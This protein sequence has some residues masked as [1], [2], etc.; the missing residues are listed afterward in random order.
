ME[1]ERIEDLNQVLG[2]LNFSSG[3]SDLKFLSALNRLYLSALDGGDRSVYAGMPAWLKIQQWLL[4]RLESL[5][6]S[7]PA[8]AE[9][10][11]ASR[12]IELVW[13]SL[14]PDYLDFHSDLLFHQEPQ[15]IFNSLF[16]GRAI[17]ATLKQ[18]LLDLQPRRHSRIN[19][20]VPAIKRRQ[21]KSVQGREEL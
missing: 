16:L 14:L 18:P 13:R 4:E 11:Q 17:E 9:S 10:E 12:V 7:N 6:R 2:Y 5:R 3:K 20:T 1:S 8:F 15:G 21:I 19:R